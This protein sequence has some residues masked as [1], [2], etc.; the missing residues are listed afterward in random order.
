M[1]DRPKLIQLRYTQYNI[2]RWMNGNK[3][4]IR[5]KYVYTNRVE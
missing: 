5:I 4:C 2:T 3:N 1:I